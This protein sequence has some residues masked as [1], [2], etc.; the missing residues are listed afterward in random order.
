MLKVVE[1]VRIWGIVVCKVL[2]SDCLASKVFN[3][4]NNNRKLTAVCLHVGLDLLSFVFLKLL[5]VLCPLL[6][7]DTVKVY[8]NDLSVLR[9]G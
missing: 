4:A 2:A 5:T 7:V 6:V 1:G 8:S 3:A 9:F